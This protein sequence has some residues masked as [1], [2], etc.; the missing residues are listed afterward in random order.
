MF[1]S[2]ITKSELVPIAQLS[3]KLVG[4]MYWENAFNLVADDL[5]PRIKNL[6]FIDSPVSAGT[7]GDMP[8][9]VSGFYEDGDDDQPESVA[10]DVF[11]PRGGEVT[12]TPDLRKKFLR[13][14]QDTIKHELIHK[15]QHSKRPS[16]MTGPDT[17]KDKRSQ[18]TE[19]LSRA[20]ETEAFAVNIADHLVRA[21]RSKKGALD[22]LRTVRNTAQMRDKVGKLLS[23]DLSGY[24]QD[25]GD[26]PKVMN[27]LYKK[28][29]QYISER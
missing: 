10:V 6:R 18:R 16:D 22:L 15:S 12:W 20:E 9:A 21:K 17:G 8:Y 5:E 24:I 27:R 14:I 2:E 4:T 19:Y 7:L 26:N 13:D 23:P 11:Y 3:K 1:V 29:F 25:I 28:I